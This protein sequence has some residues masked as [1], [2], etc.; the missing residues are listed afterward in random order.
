MRPNNQ[1]KLLIPK[2]KISPNLRPRME[3][4][5]QPRK[6]VRRRMLPK[7]QLSLQVR[8]QRRE[9]RKML[10]RPPLRIR[11]LLREAKPLPK[12][13][14]RAPKPL[15]LLVKIPRNLPVRKR[16]KLLQPKGKRRRAFQRLKQSQRESKSKPQR[17][18]LS[19]VPNQLLPLLLQLKKMLLWP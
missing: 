15:N 4:I 13:Q 3:K 5:N 14:Q 8:H 17:L 19:Q 9:L 18:G 2:I 7:S 6:K 12:P 10:K 16:K 1:R 11:N